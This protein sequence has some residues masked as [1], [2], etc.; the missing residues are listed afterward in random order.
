MS[1]YEGLKRRTAATTAAL[2]AAGASLAA[3]T[4][5]TAAALPFAAGGCVGETRARMWPATGR[6][7]LKLAG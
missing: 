3:L 4:G 1:D 2:V 5:G 7:P 6:L